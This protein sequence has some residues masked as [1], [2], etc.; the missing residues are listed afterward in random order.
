MSLSTDGLMNALNEVREE[1][2]YLQ[3]IVADA[4]KKLS[5]DNE[6]YC[7]RDMEQEAE[8]TDLKQQ[9]ERLEENLE[10]VGRMLKS[11][12]EERDRLEEE[13]KVLEKDCRDFKEHMKQLTRSRDIERTI[14]TKC[15]I[16][17]LAI[18]DALDRIGASRIDEEHIEDRAVR[19]L[20]SQHKE[21]ERLTKE[22]S[23][24]KKNAKCSSL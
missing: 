17:L 4:T 18:G 2:R 9:V 13:C 8:I 21:I 16:H 12:Q 3:S 24:L 23:Y 5:D 6:A 15:Q 22:L 1:N 14:N 19:I 10:Y 7:Q 11:A 20:C